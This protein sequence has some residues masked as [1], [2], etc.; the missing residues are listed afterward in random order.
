MATA[1][2]TISRASP[3]D[4]KS[5]VPN[6]RYPDSTLQ[7]FSTTPGLGHGHANSVSEDDERHNSLSFDNTVAITSL[8]QQSR[9]AQQAAIAPIAT[10]NLGPCSRPT[11]MPPRPKPGRKPLPQEDA[12]DRRRVQ[13]RLAQR[14]FRDKRAQK[15]SD[16]TKDIERIRK[17]SDDAVR[18]LTNRLHDQRELAASLKVENDTLRAELQAARQRADEA[19]RQVQMVNHSHDVVKS[20]NF[21]RASLQNVGNAPLPSMS[22]TWSGPVDD[23]ARTSSG[24]NPSPPEENENE[25][26]MSYVWNRTSRRANNATQN[27]ATHNHAAHNN[28]IHNHTTHNNDTDNNWLSTS[29]E[30]DREEDGCGFCTDASN[31]ACLQSERPQPEIAPVIAPVSAPKTAPG[32]CDACVADPKRA[33]A[34]R[35]IA[36]QAEFSQRPVQ[37]ATNNGNERNDSMAPPPGLV[38]CSTMLDR[39][40]SRVPSIA[41][42]FPGKFHRYPSVTSG[43]GFDV[44]EQEVAQVL[45]NMSRSDTTAGAAGANL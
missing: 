16:L 10:A 22:T 25:I 29:M 26:D 7:Q 27:N 17:E 40:G 44:N 3:A 34:C 5:L 19:E 43:S 42:L 32:G 28:T 9:P 4:A 15:V 45:H 39:L 13:N 11:Q 33:A 23:H 6:F 30:V 21:P 24:G 36:Q 8:P 1:T 31:C 2:V 12:Q 35:A 41:E 18:Q 20:L 37:A 38:S 14:N